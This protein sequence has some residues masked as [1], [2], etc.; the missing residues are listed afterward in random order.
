MGTF[1]LGVIGTVTGVFVAVLIAGAVVIMSI[2]EFLR[3]LFDM[4]QPCN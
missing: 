1:I 4:P 2:A 3:V